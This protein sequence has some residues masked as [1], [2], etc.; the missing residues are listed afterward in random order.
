M[1]DMLTA[2]KA[3]ELFNYDPIT[4]ELINKFTRSSRSMAGEIAGSNNGCGYRHV[5]AG[6]RR[7][8]NHRVIFLMKTG[9]WPGEIDHINHIRDDNR[10]ENLREASHLE[11]QRNKSLNKNNTSGVC[12]VYWRKDSQKWQT[13]I[14]VN[15]RLLHLGYYHDK[16]DAIAA[17]AAAEIKYGFHENHG[18]QT[19]GA[20]L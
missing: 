16:E 10:W 8:L 12:G 19:K 7:Y 14:V 18:L 2:S 13:L 9:R 17:R 3:R 11:N 4:G 5:K 1:S 15:N 20:I 6:G